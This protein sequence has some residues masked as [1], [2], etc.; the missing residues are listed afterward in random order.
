MFRCGRVFTRLYASRMKRQH[1]G[2][3]EPRR[4]RKQKSRGPVAAIVSGLARHGRA[5]VGD[6]PWAA[7]IVAAGYRETSGRRIRLSRQPL[8]NAR[9]RNYCVATKLI[10][11]LRE[12]LGCY[13]FE[14][15]RF[16]EG[17]RHTFIHISDHP[18][19]NPMRK[20]S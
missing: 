20:L 2:A 11:R 5:G 1:N 18:T 14:D 6:R 10:Y 7:A 3:G 8:A 15:V 17:L 13:A 19:N 4:T 9:L 12:A 16:D